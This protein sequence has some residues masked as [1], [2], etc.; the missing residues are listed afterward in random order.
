[1]L[2]LIERSANAAGQIRLAIL[3]QTAQSFDGR[4][5]IRGQRQDELAL[6]I[7]VY[8]AELDFASRRETFDQTDGPRR[9]IVLWIA[10]PQALRGV[11]HQHQVEGPHAAKDR[12]ASL[13][14]DPG[15]MLGQRRIR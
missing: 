8:D 3:V 6:G 11:E 10:A 2:E 15:L 5:A 14:V 9:A 12:G 13:D 7:E 4:R 1:M